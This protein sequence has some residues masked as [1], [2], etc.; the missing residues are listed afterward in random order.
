MYENETILQ[1]KWLNSKKNLNLFKNLYAGISEPVQINMK[2]ILVDFYIN[3]HFTL[4]DAFN[5]EM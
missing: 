5:V 1:I 4:S 2:Y 3:I